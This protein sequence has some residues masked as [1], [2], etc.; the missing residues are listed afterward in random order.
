VKRVLDA[1]VVEESPDIVARTSATKYRHVRPSS[2]SPST[3]PSARSAPVRSSD[4]TSGA[5]RT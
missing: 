1:W 5:H 4:E 2:C 3:R